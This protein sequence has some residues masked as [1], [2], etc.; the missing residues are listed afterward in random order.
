M[1]DGYQ[2]EQSPENPN[3]Q[4]FLEVEARA[5]GE[6]KGW[7]TFTQNV[8]ISPLVLSSVNRCKLEG[9]MFYLSDR[10]KTWDAESNRIEV[11]VYPA[12]E[13]YPADQDLEFNQMRRHVDETHYDVSHLVEAGWFHPAAEEG[14]LPTSAITKEDD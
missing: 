6:R 8:D 1:T 2:M 9:E 10:K 5:G 7:T 14:Q 12:Y 13:E 4:F 11:Y 3:V